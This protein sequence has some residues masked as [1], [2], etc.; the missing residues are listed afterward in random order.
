[1]ESHRPITPR[2]PLKFRHPNHIHAYV[3]SRKVIQSHLGEAFHDLSNYC[4]ILEETV[5]PVIYY[6]KTYV[7]VGISL[8]TITNNNPRKQSTLPYMHM[9]MIKPLGSVYL[10]IPHPLC[11]YRAITHLSRRG[12]GTL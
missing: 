3:F 12:Y 5:R 11:F 1:M 9:Y 6:Y 4:L 10:T 8:V 2:L 7:Y